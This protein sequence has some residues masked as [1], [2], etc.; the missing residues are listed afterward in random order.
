MRRPAAGATAHRG[1]PTR[2]T[3]G[4]NSEPGAWAP[5]VR[6]RP[7]LGTRDRRRL[8]PAGGLAET[9][10][11]THRA[12]AWGAVLP[13]PETPFPPRAL[14]C[15]S[16]E[17]RVLLALPRGGRG[18][19]PGNASPL[20]RRYRVRQGST[21]PRPSGGPQAG[22]S[23]QLPPL[24]HCPPGGMSPSKRRGFQ[25]SPASG[26]CL[27]ASRPSI[28][29][30]APAVPVH[31][32]RLSR[33]EPMSDNASP[34]GCTL[35]LDRSMPMFWRSA[36]AAECVPYAPG[37]SGPEAGRRPY[38]DDEGAVRFYARPA[39]GAAGP[40]HLVMECRADGKTTLQPLE[41][42]VG[43]APTADY[44]APPRGPV[45][46]IRRGRVRPALTEEAVAI[47][48][49]LQRPGGLRL[50]GD[51]RHLRQ[52]RE[53]AQGLRGVPGRL[54]PADHDGQRRHDPLDRGP[55]RQRVDALH[56]EELQLSGARKGPAAVRPA[57]WPPVQ[58]E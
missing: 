58:N 33:V 55:H 18:G 57:K 41:F 56:V 34:V 17:R 43:A 51:G 44:P 27:P 36:Q 16:M 15:L 6:G 26:F 40:V 13:A 24:S 53:H 11:Q 30:G 1:G 29:V 50:G 4:S 7:A 35:P 38:A 37:G 25:A 8:A 46:G 22:A 3:N 21:E 12:P 20:G 19:Q 2:S 49:R 45:S 28:N 42:R 39:A 5:Q 32:P 48:Q 23:S 47:R 10:V 9:R 52:G 54:Q 31:G 14:P